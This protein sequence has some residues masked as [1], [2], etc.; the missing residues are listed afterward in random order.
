M[1][2]CEETAPYQVYTNPEFAESQNHQRERLLRPTGFDWSQLD[3]SGIERGL[4]KILNPQP[5]SHYLS[6]PEG[7]IHRIY[8]GSGIRNEFFELISEVAQNR[9]NLGSTAEQE[10]C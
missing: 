1:K 3:V 5:Q 7:S 4:G 6:V 8:S 9:L 2:P 10:L